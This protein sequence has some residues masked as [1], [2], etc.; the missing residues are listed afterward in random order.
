MEI[1]NPTLLERVIKLTEQE[2]LELAEGEATA[3]AV[4]SKFEGLTIDYE[5]IRA[6]LL[7]G[8]RIIRNRNMT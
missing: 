6:D 2:L 3:I 1:N 8:F 4:S 7:E 5:K